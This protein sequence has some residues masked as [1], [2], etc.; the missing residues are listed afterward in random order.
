VDLGVSPAEAALTLGVPACVAE[1]EM[2]EVGNTG[3]PGEMQT[4]EPDN[5]ELYSPEV[6]AE[7]ARQMRSS[8]RCG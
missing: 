6:R 3:N 2:G 5:D 7:Y 4:P 1:A 8:W